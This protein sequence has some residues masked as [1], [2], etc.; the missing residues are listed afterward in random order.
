MSQKLY[1]CSVLYFRSTK[2]GK[3]LN[4][5]LTSAGNFVCSF[6]C[7][8][9]TVW[10]RGDELVVNSKEVQNTLEYCRTFEMHRSRDCVIDRFITNWCLVLHY[11][12]GCVWGG[13]GLRVTHPTPQP[14][15]GVRRKSNPTPKTIPKWPTQKRCF[16]AAA[17]EPKMNMSLPARAEK[18][19]DLMRK[20]IEKSSK[21]CLMLN[22]RTRKWR[23][24]FT[25]RIQ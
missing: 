2:K 20:W 19:G 5:Y 11:D 7:L 3:V 14:D 9:N 25:T 15:L 16:F 6:S 22:P 4:N 23:G 24:G 1:N 10:V 18:F 17:H 8:Q 13:G 12:F 21:N